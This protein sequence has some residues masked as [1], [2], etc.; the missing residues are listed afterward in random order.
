MTRKQD[1]LSSPL[2]EAQ[3]LTADELH[4]IRAH[5]QQKKNIEIVINGETTFGQETIQRL[6]QLATEELKKIEHLNYAHYLLKFWVEKTSYRACKFTISSKRNYSGFQPYY[7]DIENNIST[8]LMNGKIHPDLTHDEL[9]ELNAIVSNFDDVLLALFN[10]KIRE[11]FEERTQEITKISL[12]KED[13]YQEMVFIQKSL[14]DGNSNKKI[15]YLYTNGNTDSKHTEA[16]VITKDSIIQPITW[17]T[18]DFLTIDKEYNKPIFRPQ[19][20]FAKKIQAQVEN[21][22][23]STFCL[24]YLKELLKMEAKQLQEFCLSFNYYT[25][26]FIYHIYFPSP[27]VLRYSQSGLY[28]KYFVALLADTEQQ[29]LT[30]KQEKYTIATLKSLLIQSYSEA[31]TEDEKASLSQLLDNLPSFRKK[32]LDEWLPIEEKRETMTVDGTNYYLSYR[33]EFFK[34]QAQ[35]INL[36][37]A[38]SS[39]YSDSL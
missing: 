16:V 35:N 13:A 25:P 19:V 27:Q 9:D 39:H 21:E 23:C 29:I 20:F 7:N 8:F 26:G 31:P 12:N 18:Y 38:H 10:K 17:C 34:Q 36:S 32:W 1:Y 22:G 33:S 6:Q 2:K 28:N 14:R 5:Y 11:Y 24:L 4:I 15:G 30:H 3:H 37:E